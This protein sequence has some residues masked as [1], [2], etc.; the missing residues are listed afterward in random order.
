MDEFALDIALIPSRIAR[1]GKYPVA[2]RASPKLSPSEGCVMDFIVWFFVDIL[3]WGGGAFG[4]KILSFGRL[5]VSKLEPEW[6]AGFGAVAITVAFASMIY[7]I[8]KGV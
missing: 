3:C 4:L 1:F 5:R 8:K 7:M 6:V 2:D